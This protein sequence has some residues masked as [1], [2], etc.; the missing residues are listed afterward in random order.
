MNSC[1]F[2]RLSDVTTAV[3]TAA[4]LEQ[5][6]HHWPR[7]SQDQHRHTGQLAARRQRWCRHTCGGNA[8]WLHLRC[9]RGTRPAALVRVA[10]PRCVG[11]QLNGARFS[12]VARAVRLVP[13]KSL[14]KRLR[15]AS[16]VVTSD[17]MR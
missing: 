15:S 11:A 5:H 13:G 6:A 9:G 14:S 8:R 2:M 16:D 3:R 4:A 10:R 17:L 12:H 1:L 7:P